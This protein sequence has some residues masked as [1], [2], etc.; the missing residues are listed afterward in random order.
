MHRFLARD[1]RVPRWRHAW[2]VLHRDCL[3]TSTS[4]DGLGRCGLAGL[5]AVARSGALPSMRFFLHTGSLVVGLAV[6]LAQ[7]LLVANNDV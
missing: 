4:L 3:A 6:L 1:V 5:A 7:R 2:L